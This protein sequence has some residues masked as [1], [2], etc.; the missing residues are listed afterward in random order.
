MASEVIGYR[1]SAIEVARQF[2]DRK[3]NF[4]AESLWG[5]GY[6][7]STVGFEEGQIREYIRN[8]AQLDGQG[9]RKLEGF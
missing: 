4:N 1:S 8:Q 9:S 5:R 7:L 3:R 6:A 2:S